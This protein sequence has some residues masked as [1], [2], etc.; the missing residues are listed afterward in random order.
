V[1]IQNDQ[2]VDNKQTRISYYRFKYDTAFIQLHNF[3][4]F[5]RYYHII[6]G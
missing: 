5:L 4:A 1:I 6:D 2:D 3:T